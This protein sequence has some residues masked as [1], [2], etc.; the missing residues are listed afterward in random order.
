MEKNKKLSSVIVEKLRSMSND[1]K[2]KEMARYFKTGYGEYAENDV[3]L[4]IGTPEIRNVAKEYFKETNLSQTALL[5]QSKY[6]EIRRAGIEILV[7]K[8]EKEIDE[9]KRQKISLC[10]L[11]NIDRINNWDLVDASAPN[12]LGAFIDNKD[13]SILYDFVVSDNLWKQRIAIIATF[14]FIRKGN[15][16]DTLAIAEMLI[17]NKHDLIHKAIGWMLREIGKRDVETQLKFLDKYAAIMPR[18]AL[19]YALEK[20]DADLREYYMTLKE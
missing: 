10:Y 3:F 5:L 6:H 14:H 20:F 15:F 7:L 1:Q 13:K 12:L 2:A 19:R 17:D 16:E 4:G 11:N 9:H 18:T 8:M